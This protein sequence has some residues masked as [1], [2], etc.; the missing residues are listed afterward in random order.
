MTNHQ[1]R[2]RRIWATESGTVCLRHEDEFGHGSDSIREFWVPTHGGYVYEVKG[3]NHGVLGRQVCRRL[4]R[5]GSTL[6]ATPETLI[7]VIRTEYR[8]A[9]AYDHRQKGI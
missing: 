2:T 1:N 6:W 4:S 5:T 9:V 7:D 3:A 8:K